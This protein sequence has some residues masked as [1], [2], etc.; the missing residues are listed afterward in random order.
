MAFRRI[1]PGLEHISIWERYEHDVR[2]SIRRKDK[3]GFDVLW[4][5]MLDAAQAQREEIPPDLW[6]ENWFGGR[7][8][9][10]RTIM[11]GT[12]VRISTV[13]AWS[14]QMSQWARST[15]Q[16]QYRR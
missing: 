9:H 7:Y 10:Y 13:L 5:M 1:P 2:R 8:K 3:H 6:P 15:F 16:T 11:N 4:R 14:G 12:K